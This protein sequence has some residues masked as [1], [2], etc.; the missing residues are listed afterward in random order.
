VSTVVAMRARL[1]DFSIVPTVSE[2]EDSFWPEVRNGAL[3]S[4]GRPML[5]I[6]TGA[7]RYRVDMVVVAWKDRPE[8]VRAISSRR[9]KYAW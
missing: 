1:A 6:P 4:S 9:L 5:I 8:A 2:A 3:L 7:M